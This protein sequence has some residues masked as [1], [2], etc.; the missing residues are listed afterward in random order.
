MTY[1]QQNEKVVR[2]EDFL[3]LLRTLSYQFYSPD[4][5]HLATNNTFLDLKA[6]LT[7][8]QVISPSAL[9]VNIPAFRVLLEHS[10]LQDFLHLTLSDI[11]VL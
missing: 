9:Y 7:T 1:F 10:A 8:H 3:A 5:Q 2:K 11:R 6:M 4:T